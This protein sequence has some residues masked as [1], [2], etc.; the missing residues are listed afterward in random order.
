MFATEIIIRWSI[1]DQSSTGVPA[2]KLKLTPTIPNQPPSALC[3]F[4]TL[5]CFV[6]FNNTLHIKKHYLGL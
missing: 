1:Y 4:S 5:M 3:M 6:N 2:M